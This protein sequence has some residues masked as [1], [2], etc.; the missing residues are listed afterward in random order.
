VTHEFFDYY[1]WCPEWMRSIIGSH[2]A[3]PS[4]LYIARSVMKAIIKN[5]LRKLGFDIV[6]YD[7]K[8]VMYADFSAEERRIIDLA[9]PFSLTGH[10]KK[11]CLIRAVRYIVRNRI[12]GDMAECGVWRGGSMMI[13]AATLLAEGDTSRHLYLY[14]TFEGMSAPIELDKNYEGILAS[15]LL[16]QFPKNSEIWCNAD[17]SDV[18]ANLFSIGY[19]KEKIHFIKG[20]VEETIPSVLPSALSLLRLDTDWYEPTKHELVH[21]FPLLQPKGI[22]IIDDYGYWQGSRVA[23]DEYFASN[24][25]CIYL[26]RIDN[27]G[28]I[29][30]KIEG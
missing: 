22:L 29:A 24:N 17:I 1:K 27:S 12:P 19:P 20:K 16:K 3:S 11:V 23:T 18:R 2:A 28:R 5:A 8:C 4:F 10:E 7:P 9:M 14:D 6:R 15:E 21:L 30:V 25:I 26:S 13:V